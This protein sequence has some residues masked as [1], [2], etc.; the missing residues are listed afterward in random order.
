M[1]KMN[2]NIFLERSLLKNWVSTAVLYYFYKNNPSI[3]Q[4]TYPLQQE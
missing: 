4:T 1:G 3:L 2:E